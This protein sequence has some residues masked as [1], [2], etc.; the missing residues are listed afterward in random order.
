MPRAQYESAS[1]GTTQQD[2][3]VAP[4]SESLRRWDQLRYSMPDQSAPV[5]RVDVNQPYSQYDRETSDHASFSSVGMGRSDRSSM[6]SSSNYNSGDSRSNSY[7]ASQRSSV[8]SMNGQWGMPSYEQ[9]ASAPA[10][11]PMPMSNANT[12]QYP[13]CSP[14]MIPATAR[15]QFSPPFP[16]RQS[17][18]TH[19]G[20]QKHPEYSSIQHQPLIIDSRTP[21]LRHFP[22][23]LQSPRSL[24][25]YSEQAHRQPQQSNSPPTPYSETS[26]FPMG[27][28]QGPS[29]IAQ[30]M[31]PYVY[32]N[33]RNSVS[34]LL[35]PHSTPYDRQLPSYMSQPTYAGPILE[36]AGL[37]SSMQHKP[38][39]RRGNLPKSTTTLL[40]SW[41]YD[42]TNHPYPSENEKNRLA[43]QTGLT[44]NQIS[45]WFINARRRI[46]QPSDMK[47]ATGSLQPSSHQEPK[48]YAH[49]STARSSSG[50]S[51]GI[52]FQPPY[53]SR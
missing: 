26:P 12:Y 37:N 22:E 32:P 53:H 19:G 38:K 21:N 36:T 27:S 34:N 11:M 5:K 35:Q 2:T 33:R 18:P 47:P 45:N 42:H 23:P 30:S 7:S 49:G 13:L 39:R 24:V 9:Q 8:P 28:Y 4:S 3:P 31:P 52:V 48:A 40:R 15:P 25:P 41:L 51:E 44:I 46:L 1:V 50:E 14:S 6:T 43:A 29:Y 20:M 10:S 16:H 17:L